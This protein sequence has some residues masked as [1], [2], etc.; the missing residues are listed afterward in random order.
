MSGEVLYMDGG[1]VK[2][3]EEGLS[4]GSFSALYESDKNTG[5]PL[6]KRYIDAIWHVY[7]KSSPYYSLSFDMRVDEYD[8]KCLNK[9]DKLWVSCVSD[10]RFVACVQEYDKVTKT[11][12]DR[13]YQRLIDDAQKYIEYLERIPLEKTVREKIEVE[14]PETKE[15]EFRFVEM[16]V[17]NFK[18][19]KEARNEIEEQY[20][21]IDKIKERIAGQTV[22]KNRKYVRIFDNPEG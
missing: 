5:K 11:N 14:N 17:P 22:K 10:K 7:S 20:K 4:L 16:K 18:E 2:L 15:K 3:T 1:I 19:R 12:E 9:G 21:F 13:Q 8:K 6:F